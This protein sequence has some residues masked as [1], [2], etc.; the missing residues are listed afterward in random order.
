M[1]RVKDSVVFPL[2]MQRLGSA[3]T[4]RSRFI[5]RLAM[6]AWSAEATLSQGARRMDAKDH[7]RRSG[8]RCFAC[9][10]ESSDPEI[11]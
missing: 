4:H 11:Q 8:W 6:R 2:I 3:C 5:V 7:E 10:V 9:H 1:P